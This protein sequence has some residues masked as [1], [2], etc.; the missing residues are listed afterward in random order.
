MDLHPHAGLHLHSILECT[1]RHSNRFLPHH[2]GI[3]LRIGLFVDAVLIQ[4]STEVHPLAVELLERRL[5]PHRKPHDLIGHELFF[6]GRARFR[7]VIDDTGRIAA[8]ETIRRAMI[9]G[10]GIMV[11]GDRHTLKGFRSSDRGHIGEKFMLDRL[12]R[13]FSNLAAIV[14]FVPDLI[15]EIVGGL[16]NDTGIFRSKSR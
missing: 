11:H 10:I 8:I 6:K 15:G 3:A 12:Q 13:S 9:A 4:I 16:G 2:C 1:G 7:A 14:P 5:D